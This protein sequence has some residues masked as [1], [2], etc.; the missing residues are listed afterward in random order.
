VIRAMILML[1]LVS[2]PRV[3]DPFRVSTS[4]D[5]QDDKSPPSLVAQF[6]INPAGGWKYNRAYPSTAALE[7]N[8]RAVASEYTITHGAPSSVAFTTT[9]N[10]GDVSE[11]P[12]DIVIVA[13]FSLCTETSCRVWRR[14]R[15][16]VA[17]S[18][19]PIHIFHD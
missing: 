9:A 16:V 2:N 11:P 4:L 15:I 13:S 18:K 5:I 17:G 7:I 12:Y 1:A 19:A 6:T 8:G 3:D 14:Q 10:L